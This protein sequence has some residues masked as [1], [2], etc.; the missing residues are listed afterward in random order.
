MKQQLSRALRRRRA[1]EGA[2]ARAVLAPEPVRR[3][4]RR[5]PPAIGLVLNL[6]VVPGLS[7]QGAGSTGATVL[8][9]LAG[10]R[11]T[12]FS[13]AYSAARTDADVLFYNPAG[14][15]GVS[16]AAA[17]S[18]QQHVAD[19]GVAT[20]SGAYRVGRLVLGGSVIFL[21]YG[22]ID[23]YVPDPDFGGQTGRPTGST[24]SASEVAARI[25]GALPL[26]DGRLNL[27]ASAGW[28]SVDLAGTGRGTP[29]L[30]IGAQYALSAVT[31]GATLRNLGGSLSGGGVADA[32]RPKEARA[33]AMVEVTRPSGLGAVLSADL[34]S[35][36]R[37]H[38][39]GLVAGVEAGLIPSGGSRVGAVGR[40]G[41]NTATGDGGQGALLLGG[42]VSVG[43]V[44]VDYAWQ[45]YDLFGTLHRFGIRWARF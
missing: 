41:F 23:E 35:Q 4:A 21:D 32:E 3:L 24:V 33:G 7:A 17:V 10:G 20:G 38:Q 28:V 42:S 29:F 11:A 43:R 15:A 14:I 1:T 8:Q 27:G 26:M 39:T 19:I 13:G 12:G 18:Y 45:N 44:S 34:V 31:F 37:D 30:D 22:D 36:L 9:L 25:S 2:G 40:V 16:A 6:V 5:L